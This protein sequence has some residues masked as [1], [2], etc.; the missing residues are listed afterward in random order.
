M[1]DRPWID[2][3]AAVVE[4]RRRFLL[5]TRADGTHL[6]GHWEF[7]GGKVHPGE[8][9][10][11][12]IIREL[13]EELGVT[14][15]GPA[16]V[17]TVEHEYP[18]KR[19][20][21]HFMRCTLAESA[22]P[23][24][25][26]GQRAG[27]FTME[28]MAD[29][30]LA[31]ADREFVAR[32]T[33]DGALPQ[34]DPVFSMPSPHSFHIRTYGCQMNT[35]DSEA[36]ACTLEA[37]GFR[38]AAGEEDA[39]ILLFNTCS[40]RDQAE[41]KV[42]GKLGILKKRK[43]EQPG[44]VI[45]VFGCMAQ[46][47]GEELCEEI[48]H[49]DLVV[50]TDQLHRLP[51]LLRDVLATRAGAVAVERGGGVEEMEFMGRHQPGGRAA[52]VAVMRGCNQGCTYCSVPEVRGREKSR[53]VPEIVGEV[54]TLAEGGVREITLLGQNITAYGVAEA[55]RQPGGWDKDSSPFAGLLRAVSEVP[56]LAR[57]R[58][59][60][61]HPSYMNAA[62]VQALADLPKVCDHLHVPVQSG[63]DRILGLMRRGYTAAD[64]LGC[65]R[66]IQAVRPGMVFS[67]DV[68]VGFPGETDAEF[69]AT[70]ELMEAVSFDMAYIF[71]YSPRPGTV[72]ARMPDDVPQAVKEQ[73]L[74]RLLEDLD[75]RVLEHNKAAVG[76]TVEVLVE[77]PS[78]R[79]PQRWCGRTGT[80][81]MAIFDPVPGLASGDLVRVR[82]DRGTAHSLF[83]VIC[84]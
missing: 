82:V 77:G 29:L 21:L 74:A 64:Y 46:R 67:T 56:G 44:L 48:G 33:A 52:F 51:Q 24:P 54:R 31:G 68:I 5:A 18:E 84:A 42:L 58:F 66:A 27:W 3:C 4:R 43:K 28:E 81:K 17:A 47:L 45:G 13:Q 6:A 15:A 55:R 25:Q 8:T 72:A 83:G 40:V 39:G 32:L 37:E 36:V 30:Q 41:R 2:V 35:R 71:K 22:Q 59:T 61:P 11:A 62:F 19:I 20:R 12:C 79:N 23:A 78:L 70:R 50:G 57:I 9:L 75:R 7:P 10:A 1:M 63:A 76:Q 16:E 69:A 38:P 60:S 80:H 73:R 49:V 14:V 65:I 34:P 53:P 26:D